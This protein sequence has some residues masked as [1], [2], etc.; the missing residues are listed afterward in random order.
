MYCFLGCRVRRTRCS[1]SKP[2]QRTINCKLKLRGGKL[3][4]EFGIP[5]VQ[6]SGI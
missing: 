4:T 6:V 5:E 1:N 2:A 3:K